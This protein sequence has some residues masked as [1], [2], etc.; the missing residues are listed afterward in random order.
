MRNPN[1]LPKSLTTET[2]EGPAL[3]LESVNNVHSSDGLA[4]S[5]LS[6]GDSVAN[7][8]LEEDLEN[9]ASF[10][11]DETTDTL[12]ATTSRQTPNRGLRDSLNVIPQNLTV[13][14]RSSLS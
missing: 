10:F 13:P 14:L 5:V 11:I 8:V 3:P 7:D 2:I 6:I 4:A 12:H 9:T 1:P